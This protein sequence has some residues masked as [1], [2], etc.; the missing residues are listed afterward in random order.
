M[1]KCF[2]LYGLLAADLHAL[3][4]TRYSGPDQGVVPREGEAQVGPGAQFD[5]SKIAWYGSGTL[6]SDCDCV[7][8]TRGKCISH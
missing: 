6:H 5:T 7:P 8:I 3:A 2:H 4:E 1:K